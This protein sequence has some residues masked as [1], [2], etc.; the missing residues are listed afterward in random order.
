ML[1]FEGGAYFPHRK[2]H[3]S[4]ILICYSN[5]D[6]TLLVGTLM[7]IGD[8]SMSIAIGYDILVRPRSGSVILNPQDLD[9]GKHWPL[10]PLWANI[11]LVL[12]IA[13]DPSVQVSLIV[14]WIKPKK[15]PYSYVNVHKN[16]SVTSKTCVWSLPKSRFFYVCL[17]L[18]YFVSL[19]NCGVFSISIRY[20]FLCFLGKEA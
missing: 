3:C 10:T 6:D 16:V 15:T 13:L 5:F 8:V 20:I 17:F 9:P 19:I 7:W 14:I 4:Q 11:L 1:Q 18:H 2:H 12:L